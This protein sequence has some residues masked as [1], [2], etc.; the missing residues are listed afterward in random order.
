MNA[1]LSELQAA[2]PYAQF[3]AASNINARRRYIWD[4]YFV[5]LLPLVRNGHITLPHVPDNTTHNANVFYIRIIGPAQRQD[6][7]QHMASAN[8]QTHP[9]FMPLHSSPFGRSHGRF[10]GVDRVTSLA[11]SQ[12]LLQSVYLAL[13]DEA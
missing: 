2:F 8:V 12:I 1:I 9:Q 13:S 5:S 10:D 4:R 7:I 3:Q 6:L 11:S